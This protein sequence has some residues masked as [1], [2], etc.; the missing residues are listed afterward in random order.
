MNHEGIRREGFPGKEDRQLVQRPWGRLYP[1]CWEA[2]VRSMNN[3]PEGRSQGPPVEPLFPSGRSGEGRTEHRK[4][5]QLQEELFF[6]F[7]KIDS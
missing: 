3:T 7:F 6:I 5:T 4:V 2:E 1:L